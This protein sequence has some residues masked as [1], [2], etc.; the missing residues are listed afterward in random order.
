MKGM[1]ICVIGAPSTG[2]SVFA[3]SLA[4]ELGKRGKS[5]ELVQEYA[6]TY[7]QQVGTPK[8]MW[9]QLVICIGQHLNEQQTKREFMVTD[10]AVF[11][12]YV[13]A[14][15]I[16]AAQV[17]KVEWPRY[18]HLLDTLRTMARLSVESYDLIF[19]LTHVFAPRQDGVRFHL[20]L[21]ECKDISRELE[22][23]LQSER[24]E[25]IRAKA[26]SGQAVEQAL[27]LIEQ[28]LVIQKPLRTK[29]PASA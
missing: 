25:Y 19:F 29:Q 20:S 15:R 13:Y 24:V 21:E 28:R 6:S 16:L 3:K 26:N 11:A 23:Y 8:H 17:P 5:C 27:A 22:A 4:A 1:K 9:E 14:Q 2:K 18:R 7:I 12:T 10:A